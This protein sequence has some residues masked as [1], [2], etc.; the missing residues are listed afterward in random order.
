M[1]KGKADLQ[2][3]KEVKDAVSIPVIGNGDV[4][5]PEEAKEMLDIT[6]VDAVM[7]A[8]EARDNPFIFSQVN[9]YLET[10]KYEENPPIEK[11]IEMLK[12]YHDDL[13]ELKSEK[14]A[15]LLTRGMS[16]N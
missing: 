13:V 3:I 14:Q 6:G 12:T 16:I 4:T 11:V 2:K 8:R 1:Y 9:D 10:G 5:T 7:I 15:L